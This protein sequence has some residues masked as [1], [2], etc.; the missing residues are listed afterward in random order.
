MP[1]DSCDTS[2]AFLRVHTHID[3]CSL[4]SFLTG[5]VGFR[6]IQVETMPRWILYLVSVWTSGCFD[7][8]TRCASFLYSLRGWEQ[9]RQSPKLLHMLRLVPFG[10]SSWSPWPSACDHWSVLSEA[11][12]E[13]FDWKTFQV[14]HRGLTQQTC[15]SA[16]YQEHQ[17]LTYRA[18]SERRPPWHQHP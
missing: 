14:L 10:Q 7:G 15:S 18:R 2:S 9:Y 12:N 11:Y 16:L 1:C 17:R 4:H 13:L 6:S 8:L 3:T 5:L